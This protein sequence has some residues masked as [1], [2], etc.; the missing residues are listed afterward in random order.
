MPLRRPLN[1]FGH[2]LLKLC[3]QRERSIHD[4]ARAARLKG[5]SRIYYAISAKSETARSTPL[6]E[7]ELIRIAETLKLSVEG[8][9]ELIITAQLASA[10]QRLR[11]YVRRLE[12][13][14]LPQ[15]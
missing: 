11:R 13:C 7:D 6:T 4:V 10:P 3:E 14:N 9:E 2:Y 15:K 1:E 5:I 8:Q 12:A